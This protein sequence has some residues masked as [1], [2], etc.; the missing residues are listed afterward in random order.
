MNSIKVERL[1]KK[2]I[3]YIILIACLIV[4]Y[5][6]VF[7]WLVDELKE[8]ELRNFD[9][10]IIEFIQSHISDRLTFVMKAITF[11]GGKLGIVLGV[12]IASTIFFFF[13]KRY[14]LYLILSSGLGALFNYFLK[15][16]FQ[17]ERPDFYPLIVEHGYSFPSGH[18]MASFIF[19]T[20]LAVVLAKVAKNK[21]L[22]IV[23][24]IS[25]AVIVLLI[26]ISRIYLGVHFPSD[27]VAGF[28]AGGFWVCI[29]GL[30]LNYYEFRHR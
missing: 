17:R 4:V 16:L 3:Q 15:W 8:N 26:G 20:S 13:K 18:S 12:L 14:A 30:A 19:Y 28:A 2:N 9:Y 7:S 24:A 10:T 6:F 1:T 25:F 5:S 21:L 22:D 27:V 29:C 11:F 23:I